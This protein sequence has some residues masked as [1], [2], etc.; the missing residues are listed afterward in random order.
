M[1]SSS[2]RTTLFTNSH[3]TKLRSG[4]FIYAWF[5]ESLIGPLDPLGDNRIRAFSLVGPLSRSDLG[6]I[7]KMVPGTT[8]IILIPNT[9]D[10]Y[11]GTYHAKKHQ[12]CVQNFQNL[13]ITQPPWPGVW[14]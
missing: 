6:V 1:L 4:L 9:K 11:F 3:L 7:A 14:P 2:S 13:N 10:T 5:L 8:R 12:F